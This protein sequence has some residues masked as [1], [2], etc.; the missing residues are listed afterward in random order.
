MFITR[1]P[2][3][4]GVSVR[5][6]VVGI[7][8]DILLYQPS[9]PRYSELCLYLLERGAQPKEEESIKEVVRSTFQ[10]VSGYFDTL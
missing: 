8:K 3:N 2:F 6:T 1:H 7:M 9:H 5:K 4:T 10:Q